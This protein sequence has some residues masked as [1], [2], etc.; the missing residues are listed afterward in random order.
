MWELKVGGLDDLKALV[1]WSHT[2]C[3][4]CCWNQGG[5]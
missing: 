2:E 1:C 4:H 3:V 5:S